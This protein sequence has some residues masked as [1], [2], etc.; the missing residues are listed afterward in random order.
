MS[1]PS[2]DINNYIHSHYYCALLRMRAL[3]G[4]HTLNR[5]EKV[6]RL[7]LDQPYRW[8]QPCLRGESLPEAQQVFRVTVV[9][10]FCASLSL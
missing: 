3:T 8:L 6:F 10:A 1:V 7:K 4:D 2:I 5:D 9:I